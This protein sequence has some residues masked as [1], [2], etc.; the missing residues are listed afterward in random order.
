[1]S[2]PLIDATSWVLHAAPLG[3]ADC[4][5]VELGCGTGRNVAR[6]IG[7][8]ARSYQGVDG[9]LGM[10]AVATHR[11]YDPRVTFVQADLLAPWA[12][13]QQFDFALLCLVLE[14]LPALDVLAE[15]LA[16]AV[17]PGGRIRI[18]DLHPERVA[19]GAL[20]HFQDGTTEVRFAS[21][22]HPVPS[23]CDALE[24]TGF[25]VVRRDWLASDPMIAA[26][27]A[28]EKH[29]GLKV[30]LDIKATRRRRLARGSAG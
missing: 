26:V 21:V 20:A 15:T 14:H 19:A 9:S 5:V 1:V 12:P 8:G 17:K 6:V 29:R 16:R 4:E 25:D 10:L 22:S 11:Y 28:L 30:V 27:P 2:N 3:C 7:E 18:V 24:A 13:S 23:I